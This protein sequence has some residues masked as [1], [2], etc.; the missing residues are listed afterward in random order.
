MFAFEFNPQQDSSTN[1]LAILVATGILVVWASLNGGVYRNWFLDALEGSFVLNL[2]ILVGATFYIKLTGGN[3]LAVGYTLVS[4]AFATFIGI[5]TFQ[6]A[7]VTGISQ[8][9][10]IKC[11]AVAITNVHQAEAEVEPQDIDSLPDWLLN[12]GQ[13]EPPLHTPPQYATAEPTEKEGLVQKE[14]TPVYTYGSTV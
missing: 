13:Y 9:L 3:Q 11:A 8:Y 2:I 6:L 7:K 1:L 10:K 12:P 4:I 5:L 14:L